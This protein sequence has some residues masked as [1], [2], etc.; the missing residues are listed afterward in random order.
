[1]KSYK[2][3]IEETRIVTTK[4]GKDWR[5]VDDEEIVRDD[6]YC[7]DEDEPKTRI[8]DVMG[9]TPEIEKDIPETREIFSQIV[10]ELNISSVIT[11]I[12]NP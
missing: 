12:N 6:K 10:D 11:A 1:M 2:I 8:R 4:S 3:T 7:I 5:K 9:Y